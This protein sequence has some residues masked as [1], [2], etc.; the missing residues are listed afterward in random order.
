MSSTPRDLLPWV[1]AGQAGA[2]DLLSELIEAHR[3]RGP[4]LTLESPEGAARGASSV[5]LIEDSKN[6][7]G[8][9]LFDDG[10]LVPVGAVPD[11]RTRLK[12]FARAAA[13]LLDRAHTATCAAVLSSREKRALA[14]AGRAGEALDGE[15]QLWTAD[16]IMR[17]DLCNALKLGLSAAVYFGHGSPQGW[18][19]YSGLT[20][21]HFPQGGDPAAAIFSFCCDVT[22]RPAEGFS[23]AEDLVLGGHC[24]AFLGAGLKTMH[25]W[26]VEFGVRVCREMRP[27]LTIGDVL[28]NSQPR[29]AIRGSY[30]LIGDPAVPI[31]A[32]PD[33]AARA[34]AV[35]AP[36]PDAELP[37]LPPELWPV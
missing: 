36:A 4:V 20:A 29:I 30:R 15:C 8:L 9:F 17:P 19:A 33:A 25:N 10:R 14:A 34:G 37:P 23:F 1:V 28:L 2:L 12:R 32:L 7:P 16:R 5:L 3:R 35:F 13:S 21:R 6:V 24:G 22:R 11:D 27:G 26:N 31:S 18:A